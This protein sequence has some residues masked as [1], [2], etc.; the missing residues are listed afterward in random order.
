MRSRKTKKWWFWAWLIEMTVQKEQLKNPDPKCEVWKN[1]IIVNA[2]HAKEA[3]K[4]ASRIGKKESGDCRGTLRLD[5]KPAVTIFVGI[6]NMGLVHDGLR[7]GAE[8]VW[9]LKKTRRSRAIAKAKA[10]KLLIADAQQ[11]LSY[12]AS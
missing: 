5:G 3:F 7:D 9:E 6:E 11:E 4:K 8:I 12:R 1:L 2:C 10:K